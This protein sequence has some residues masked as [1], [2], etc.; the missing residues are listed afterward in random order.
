MI[1]AIRSCLTSLRTENQKK[2]KKDRDLWD[3]KIETIISS[4]KEYINHLCQHPKITP[5]KLASLKRD[6]LYDIYM[7]KLETF[8]YL[9]STGYYNHSVH[10]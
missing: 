4:Y 10:Y 6:E 7:H 3:S 8:K 5:I 9:M 1:A 2:K